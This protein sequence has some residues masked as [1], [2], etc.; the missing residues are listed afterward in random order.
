MFDDYLRDMIDECVDSGLLERTIDP[1][2]EEVY[3]KPTEFGLRIAGMEDE[4]GH[5]EAQETD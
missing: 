1:E 2:T 5:R 4:N 3:Y